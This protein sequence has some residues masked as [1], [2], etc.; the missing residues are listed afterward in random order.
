MIY[1]I[2]IQKKKRK[3]LKH[4]LLYEQHNLKITREKTFNYS[5]QR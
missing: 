5:K 1:L 4:N 2:K 3:K